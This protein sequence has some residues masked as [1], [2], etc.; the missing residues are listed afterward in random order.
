M[1]TVIFIPARYPST[2]FPGK[3]LAMLKGATGVSRSL[4]HRSWAAAMAVEGVDAVYVLTDDARIAEAAGAFGAEVLMTSEAPRN[5]T[6]RCAEALGMLGET[7]DV[8]VNLQGDAPLTPSHYVKALVAEMAEESVQMA[9]PVLRTEVEH[10]E[11]LQ[12]DR[13][14]G[15]VGATTAVF[16]ADRN[17]LYFSKEVLPFADRARETGLAVYHHV[18]CY[19][20]R[21]E[22]LARYAA[23]P[24]GPLEEA[25]GLEQLRF[26]ENGIPVRCVEVEARGRAFWELNNPEDIPLIEAIMER[27]SIE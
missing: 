20:Y 8:V 14:A 18:G 7:P 2:R 1:Q 3:P 27:E 13:K 11:A 9:T 15:R 21:P 26:L 23:L 16:G 22:A 6:E 19:A 12:A 25:E 17:A 4:I 24:P 5:G 10:L